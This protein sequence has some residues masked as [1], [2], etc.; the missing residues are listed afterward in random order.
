MLS[1]IDF[2]IYFKYFNDRG[3]NSINFCPLDILN[4]TFVSNFLTVVNKSKIFAFEDFEYFIFLSYHLFFFLIN[5]FIGKASKN[6]FAI[7]IVGKLGK[8]VK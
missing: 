4:P 1:L 5:C 3:E 2:E 8:S 6:S 7:N